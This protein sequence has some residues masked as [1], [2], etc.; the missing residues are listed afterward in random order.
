VKQIKTE[1]ARLLLGNLQLG[2]HVIDAS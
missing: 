2:L 1:Y